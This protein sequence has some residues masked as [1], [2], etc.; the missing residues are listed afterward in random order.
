MPILYILQIHLIF[1]KLIILNSDYVNV[2]CNI[3]MYVSIQ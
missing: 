2:L 1:K 3:C